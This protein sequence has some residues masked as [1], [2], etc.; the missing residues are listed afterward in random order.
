MKR[1]LFARV[2]EWIGMDVP[3]EGTEDYES[4][5]SKLVEI[6]SIENIHDVVDYVESEGFDLDDFLICG[7]Y[8]VISAGLKANDVPVELVTKV[9]ELVAEQSGASGSWTR[10]YLFDTKYFIVNEA[11][12]TVV[13]TEAEALKTASITT[14]AFDDITSPRVHPTSQISSSKGPVTK[15]IPGKN[16]SSGRRPVLIIVTDWPGGTMAFKFGSALQAALRATRED[17]N[18]IQMSP[19]RIFRVET[20][21]S[22]REF[23]KA[24]RLRDVTTGVTVLFIDLLVS[25]Q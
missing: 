1:D 20:Q 10:V 22:E 3:D 17:M 25:R 18:L 24:M 19:E 5:Q 16:A 15:R 6:H 12:N 8:E 21:V 7:E 2:D 14:D 23:R 13:E 11:G 4:W 9:G